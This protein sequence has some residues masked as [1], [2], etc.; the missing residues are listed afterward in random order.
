[1]SPGPGVDR[2]CGVV[3]SGA[4]SSDEGDFDEAETSLKNHIEMSTAG[5]LCWV[6]PR[7][8]VVPR[9][10]PARKKG[11][12]PSEKI[13]DH[14]WKGK[15]PVD[16]RVIS[17]WLEDWPWEL[18]ELPA[19]KKRPTAFGRELAPLVDVPDLDEI[20]LTP[21]EIEEMETLEAM[22]E[23]LEKRVDALE[24]KRRVKMAEEARANAVRDADA[25]REAAAARP[26]PPTSPPV[27]ALLWDVDNVN[28]GPDPR[29]AAVVARR[30]LAAAGALGGG[31]LGGGDEEKA[32]VVAFR[33][34]ANPQTLSR[35]D[36]NA[37]ESA[38]ATIVPAPE[39]PDAVD[40]TMGAHIDG[41]I[42]AWED[43][44]GDASQVT[45]ASSFETET[46]D[47]EIDATDEPFV[48]PR[49]LDA[50]IGD[51]QDASDRDMIAGALRAAA[52][53][54]AEESRERWA[55]ETFA[56]LEKNSTESFPGDAKA[57]LMVVTTD[58]DLAPCLRR[59]RAAGI[60]VIICGDYLPRPKRG[61][62]KKTKAGRRLVSSDAG[63]G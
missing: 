12:S 57:A 11:K 29:R 63:V 19:G 24:A 26:P 47:D 27:V 6:P 7:R 39:G 17:P 15:I 5:T 20:P 21:E 62:V 60:S 48:V 41:F 13:G 23:I 37:V 2:R 42:R 32:N 22:V 43:I 30:L 45:D 46:D 59:C 16:K 55:T 9:A 50:L 25:R 34:Y 18:P 53:L 52:S 1:M 31:A 38:G 51:V 10:R 49:A 35:I 14:P 36:T 56:N 4:L 40:M 44:R 8:G 3:D 28:P 58:N 54:R 61:A 33:A